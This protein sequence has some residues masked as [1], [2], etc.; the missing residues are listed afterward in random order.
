MIV[1][2]SMLFVNYAAKNKLRRMAMFHT[3]VFRTALGGWYRCKCEWG[4]DIYE[5]QSRRE[6]GN[7]DPCFQAGDIP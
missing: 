4:C 7:V 5:N 2:D 6:F 3:Y 1:D